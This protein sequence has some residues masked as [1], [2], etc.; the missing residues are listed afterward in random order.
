MKDGRCEIGD[1]LFDW[2]RTKAGDHSQ[3]WREV[4]AII[5]PEQ[6]GRFTDGVVWRG[7]SAERCALHGGAH[8]WRAD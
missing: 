8:Y 7:S 6:L 3:A 4:V 1:V 2:S 5:R